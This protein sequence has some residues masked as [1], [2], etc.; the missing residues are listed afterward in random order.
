MSPSLRSSIDADSALSFPPAQL[1]SGRSGFAFRSVVALGCDI[2]GS[3][4]VSP[5]IMLP[6]TKEAEKKGPLPNQ[7]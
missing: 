6:T 2:L 3:G 7:P 4:R 5:C 1:P